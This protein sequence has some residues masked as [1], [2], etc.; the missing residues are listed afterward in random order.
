[1]FAFTSVSALGVGESVPGPHGGV[2]SGMGR[3]LISDKHC[4]EQVVPAA[5]LR[6]CQRAEPPALT[7]RM[8]CSIPEHRGRF[9]RTNRVS[10][11][12]A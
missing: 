6:K 3:R 4:S 12:A 9:L 2:P 7:G 11:A 10:A 8:S 5:R 1:M